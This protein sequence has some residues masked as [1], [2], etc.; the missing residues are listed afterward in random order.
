MRANFRHQFLHARQAATIAKP[1]R[2]LLEILKIRRWRHRKTIS[3]SGLFDRNWYLD[4]YSDVRIAGIDPVSHYLDYGAKEGRN[5]SAQF[6]TA[7]YLSKYPDAANSG[8]NPLLHYIRHGAKEGRFP[9]ASFE[10]TLRKISEVGG[11]V[12]YDVSADQLGACFDRVRRE[13]ALLGEKDPYWSVL[14]Q[15]SHKGANLDKK[16]KDE[17][18][19]SGRD[20]VLQLQNCLSRTG[21]KLPKGVCLEFGC[22]TGRVTKHLAKLFDRVIAIDVSPGNLKLA[23]ENMQ[24]AG[25]SNVSLKLLESPEELM[26]LPEY[27][28]LFSTI[29]F[30]HNPP[31]LQKFFLDKLLARIRPGGGAYF[32]IP[33]HTPGYKFQIEEYLNN[34]LTSGEDLQIMVEMHA[35]PMHVVFEELDQH[36]MVPVEVLMDSWTNLLGSHTFFSTKRA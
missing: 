23:T 20:T 27:D 30:Q 14:S 31:P 32:Q 22:G 21:R 19:A 12:D 10:A 36:D 15:D 29:V 24:N 34:P 26:S 16:A 6:D 35:L 17:F 9:A 7:W 8:I 2:K 33:T 3:S 1:L 4:Q 28:F 13:W 5:P 25:I 18:F 11:H